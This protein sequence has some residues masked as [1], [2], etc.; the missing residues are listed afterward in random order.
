MLVVMPTC[1]VKHRSLFPEVWSV[2]TVT[3]GSMVAVRWRVSWHGEVTAKQPPSV[4]CKRGSEWRVQ[5][6][7]F[8]VGC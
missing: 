3:L 5:S 4:P 1:V 8:R 2:S 7:G 6:G